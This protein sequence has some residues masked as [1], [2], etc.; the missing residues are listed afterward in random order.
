MRILFSLLVFCLFPPAVF[1][2]RVDVRIQEV[3]SHDGVGIA[4]IFLDTEGQII[5][6]VAA[7][8]VFPDHLEVRSIRTGESALGL[9]VEE[10]R[11]EHNKITFVGAIPNGLS[12]SNVPLVAVVFSARDMAS[13]S[14][15]ILGD[16]RAF[17][18]AEDG[19][20][21]AVKL[22]EAIPLNFSTSTTSV[23]EQDGVLPED[24]FVMIVRNQD[25]FDG[26]LVAIF[27]AVD[28]QSGIDYFEMQEHRLRTPSTDGWVRARS[29][30]LLSDQTRLSYVSVKAVDRA[31][32]VRIVTV[33]PA[34]LG[35]H[36]FILLVV[37][38]LIFLLLLY[39]IARRKKNV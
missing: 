16:V 19:G 3:L 26:R 37:G 18:H 38:A 31:G 8:I 22:P 35:A 2:A 6:V 33:A 36:R 25:I 12:H 27:S 23:L 39:G 14:A 30:Q 10:P 5:N 11:V 28:K 4:Q 20:S 32:N 15:V 29:P 13:R 17:L 7:S 24:F 34:S 9:W 21:V 1:A